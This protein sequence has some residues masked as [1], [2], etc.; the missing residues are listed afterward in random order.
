VLPWLDFS[1]YK[2]EA[3]RELSTT[4]QTAIRAKATGAGVPRVEF[5]LLPDFVPENS[6]CDYHG[7]FNDHRQMAEWMT[8][9]LGARPELWRA[10][11]ARQ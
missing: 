2:D 8:A 9:W 4:V 11:S 10:P 1:K 5:P 3:A 7:S 6:A